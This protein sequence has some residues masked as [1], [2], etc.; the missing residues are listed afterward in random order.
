M[1]TKVRIVVACFVVGLAAGCTRTVDII[2]LQ[3]RDGLKYVGYEDKPFTGRAEWVLEHGQKIAD[4]KYKD[5]KVDGPW[6]TWHSNDQK[7]SEGY[8]HPRGIDK[9]G[10]WTYW[11]KDGTLDRTET[12]YKDG[13]LDRTETY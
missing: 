10:T 1:K 13:T 6:T 7:S 11:N 9:V 3:E 8:F 12:Y 2:D 5:G 4:Q